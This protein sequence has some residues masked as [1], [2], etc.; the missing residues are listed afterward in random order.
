MKFKKLSFHENEILF[1]HDSTPFITAVEFDGNNIM[2]VFFRKEND[3]LSKKETFKPFILLED[4]SYMDDWD[5]TYEAKKLKGEAYYKYLV[6]LGNWSDLQLLLKHFKKITGATPASLNA[7][8]L[9]LNDPVHQYLLLSGQTL[10]K[11]MSFNDLVRLQLDIETYCA[12]G[13]EFSNPYREEDRITVIS[14][15]DSSG[16]EYVISGREHSE[17][18]MLEIMVEQ[19][20]SRDP[21]VIEGHNIFNFDLTY[22]TAR[23]RRHKVLLA[24]GR[25]QRVVKSHPSRLNIAE[26]TI[27]Y[28]KFEVYGRHIVDTYLLAQMY[29]VTAR[30]LESY[31]LKSV[32]KH[33][34][35]A[36]PKRTYIEPDKLS[37]YYDNKPD[38]LL[39]Y[40]MDDVRET[41]AI[42]EILSQSFFYQTRIFPYSFQNAI[43]RGNATKINS[44]FIREYINASHTIPRTSQTREYSGGY[45][46]MFFQGVVKRVLYCDVQSLYPSIMLAFKYFPKNDELNIFCTLLEGLKDFR[47]K[48]KEMVNE[49]K[50]KSEKM[51][52]DALQATFK[53]L[54]NSFYGYLG[55]AYGNFGDFDQA[56]KVTEKGRNIIKSMVKWLEDSD[57]KVI[58]IDTD[59]IFFVPPDSVKT[60][61]TEMGLIRELSDALPAGINLE[62]AGRYKAMFSY[63][64][65][66][67]VLLD[68]D[69]K[70]VIKGSG[71]RSRG[72]ELF[73]R[74]FMEEIFLL[75]L[76]GEEG[77]VVNLLEKY[78]EDIVNH[79]WDKKMFIKTETLK[80]SLA[81]Y[82]EK[83]SKKKRSAA[84]A[85]EL[86]IKSTRNYQPGDQISYYVIGDKSRVRVFDNC[87]LASQWDHKEPDENIE[88]YK[89]KLNT[90]YEKFKPFFTC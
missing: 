53:I 29:D 55:F 85:Y 61:K 72:L 14:L 40:G 48:A 49:A 25:G 37:W 33:F 75:M 31:G 26:R 17:K 8:F 66:N 20:D 89:K 47:L 19:I 83:I 67:Y 51:Y 69:D 24:L 78:I 3:V 84:A 77:K 88:Y 86:A 57:C 4:T 82:S 45:T 32:A 21:D 7:P 68:Y 59:G 22:I 23:A 35:V 18:K 74:K 2:E 58:E 64:I 5:G 76:K 38:E 9:Y 60:K 71:L 16:W 62:L 10:F 34:N 41:R 28:K 42:S 15:S 50:S 90:L 65:K 52:F 12:E 79:K 44:L 13:F 54:I 80:E 56:N 6:F 43:I 1:G 11:E 73:Q 81:T 27:S 63:K 39:K 30:N 70:M 46:D 87:K 36:S